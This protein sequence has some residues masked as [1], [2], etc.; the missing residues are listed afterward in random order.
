[1]MKAILCF[2]NHGKPRLSKFY[3]PYID[4]SQVKNNEVVTKIT[5]SLELVERRRQHS[6]HLGLPDTVQAFGKRFQG[7]REYEWQ[8][9]TFTFTSV[10]KQ[11]RIMGTLGAVDNSQVK[12]NEVVTKITTS[13][14]LVERRRQHSS[15]LGLPDT[16]Q[17][18]GK[19]FQLQVEPPEET[20]EEI[21]KMLAWRGSE[22]KTHLNRKLKNQEEAKK[23]E[24]GECNCSRSLTSTAINHSFL[25]AHS[26]RYQKDE[27][28]NAEISWKMI[29]IVGNY[30]SIIFQLLYVEST[31]TQ[32][33][34]NE[35]EID[36]P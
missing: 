1:M 5:T 21:Y 12:N 23:W 29:Q 36:K 19:R 33:N 26:S 14:E 27:F 9:D 3:Q 17:A 16:V 11:T 13:L 7:Y 18:F 34:D 8:S 31:E 2:N 25:I 28:E 15:H 24:S 32:Q 22:R 4:N 10:S 35:K 20:L 6:S 30:L